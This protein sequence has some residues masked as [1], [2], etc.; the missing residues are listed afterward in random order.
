MKQQ[1]IRNMTLNITAIDALWDP[2]FAQDIY[3][4]PQAYLAPAS[5]I[6]ISE[7]PIKWSMWDKRRHA[8]AKYDFEDADLGEPSLFKLW[9]TRYAYGYN[10]D[11]APVRLS[12]AVILAYCIVT[13]AYL[14]YILITR[15][16][17]TECNSSIELVALALQSKKPSLGHVS[18]GIDTLETF[19]EGVGIRVN[20]ENEL[21]LVFTNDSDFILENIRK[22]ERNKDY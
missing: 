18:V 2:N 13:I 15:T 14:A 16:T 7:F 9:V 1:N 17:S 19:N 11:S 20:A 10:T 22:I 21:E 8:L 6:A 4:S 12:M 5:A 3:F